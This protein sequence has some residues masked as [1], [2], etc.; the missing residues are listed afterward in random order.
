MEKEEFTRINIKQSIAREI[1]II[2]A[3]ENRP[4]YVVVSDMLELYKAT[5]IRAS[6]RIKSAK[7]VT[8][9]EFIAAQ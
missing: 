9:A 3:A 5:S 2:A 4:V 7:P 1:N 6:K 8:V